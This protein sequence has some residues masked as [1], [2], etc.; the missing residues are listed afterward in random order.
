MRSV[1]LVVL[2][3]VAALALFFA[4][5]AA[6]SHSWSIYHW[7]RTASPFTVKLGNN[8][9]SNWDAYLSEASTDWTASTV[10]D[11]AI[12][13]GSASN[14]KRCSPPDGRVEV[15]N[16]KY[17]FNGWLGVAGIYV[18][19]G[20]IYKGY[21]KLNDSYFNTSTYNKPE[22]RR[23]VMC[24]EVGHEFGLDHQDE[25]FDNPNLGTCMDY[26]NN[27]KGPPSNEHPNQHDYGQL[28]TI[29]SHTDSTTT[30]NTTQPQSGNGSRSRVD[31]VDRHGNGTVTWIFWVN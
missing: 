4:F 24:Q 6:A 21:V 13:A 23:L 3:A 7:G 1:R 31:N 2:A 29:Y 18:T 11:T 9:A 27:P 25:I 14:V 30:V 19:G 12:V 15:C 22:W 28:E 17:G 16:A 10:L 26:T 5:P 20:H 8:V